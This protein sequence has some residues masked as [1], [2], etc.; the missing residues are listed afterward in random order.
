MFFATENTEYTENTERILNGRDKMAKSN[1]KKKKIVL[2]YS[3]GLD[4]S[5]IIPWLKET[6]DYEVIA[7]AADL[8]QG[9]ELKGLKEKAIKSGASKIYIEDL[10]K[11]FI[12]D[13]IFPTIKAGAVYEKKYLLG[14]S[15]G[16]PLIAK[17]QVEIAE[18]EGAVAV[19]HGATGKGNDQVRFEL[20]FMA[21][22]PKLKIVAPWKDDNWK[23]YSREEAID[24]C[25]K[26]NV[27]ITV[28][29]KKIYSEDKNIWHISHEGGLLELPEN[30]PTDD[31]FTMSNTIEK[32]PNKAA[33]ITIGFNKGVPVSLDGKK[34]GPVEL[35]EY[36]N[37][38]GGKH[39]IGQMGMVENRLVGIKSRGVYE[40]PAGSILYYAH[41][42][43][44]SLCLN[45]ETLQYKELI[46][47]KYAEVVYNGRWF[48]PL[49]EALDAFVNSTQETVTGEVRL[50]LYKG[51][52]RSAG[53]K[54]KNS[55]YSED[56]AS[57]DSDATKYDM[58]D[59]NGFIKLFGLDM[60]TAAVKGLNKSI[61]NKILWIYCN[62]KNI[63]YYYGR[64]DR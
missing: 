54:S 36:L 17:R 45:K 9:S 33:Y 64:W 43:L 1:S 58:K 29:K 51:N 3:G 19:C 62:G 13:Y 21:L 37:K 50:K 5:A 56:L 26:H 63:S 59:A 25:K 52:I 55:L 6:Y 12:T 53:I 39:A 16:R 42:D 30:E 7:M 31:V 41:N 40:T 44:E 61:K 60:T 4:T 32:A 22:N 35:L 14:T 20:T 2:A 24:Y 18:K 47:L 27:P 38:L 46:A 15:F 23:I 28:S 11:E 8:G 34:Y 48:S 49:R 10:R 57:F